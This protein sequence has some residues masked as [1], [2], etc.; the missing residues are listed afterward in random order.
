[1]SPDKPG[2]GNILVVGATSGIARQLLRRLAAGEAGGG[3]TP[4]LIL[5][6]REIDELNRLSADLSARYG[7]PVATRRYDAADLDAAPAF[8]ADAAGALPGGLAGVVIAHGWLP[9]P[10]ASRSDPA[11]IRRLIDINY[12]SAVLLLESAAAYFEP[13]RR[14][15]ICGISSVAG[16]RGRQS[17]YPYGASKAAFSA[18]L[19][20]LRNRLHRAG[21]SVLTVKPGFVD[22]AMTWGLINPRSPLNV[23]PDRVAGDIVRAIRRRRNVIYTPWFWR[24]ILGVLGSIPEWLFKRLRT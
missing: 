9:D 22:T 21:V 10:A 24:I 4:G 20:G 19:Q 15:W 16:D 5:A 12:T 23:E 3:A 6:G 2:A 13:L 11:T 18:Y 17:N 8:F 14:G 1:M 7:C